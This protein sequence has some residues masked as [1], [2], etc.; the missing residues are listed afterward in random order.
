MIFD[1][2][3]IVDKTTMLRYLYLLFIK[4]SLEYNRSI[5]IINNL[6]ELYDK[7]I[8]YLPELLDI[9]N[10]STLKKLTKINKLKT[11]FGRIIGQSPSL[12][13]RNS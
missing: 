5:V 13:A 10:S 8:K 1:K 12:P 3:T 11:V 7:L 2:N 4:Y 9:S 6:N